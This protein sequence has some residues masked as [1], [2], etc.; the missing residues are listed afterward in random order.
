MLDLLTIWKVQFQFLLY[1]HHKRHFDIL[2][3]NNNLQKHLY[4]FSEDVSSLN[5]DI[6]LYY[7]SLLI[8]K[9]LQD[10]II[11]VFTFWLYVSYW[12]V[13]K[14]FERRLFSMF[15]SKPILSFV[16]CFSLRIYILPWLTSFS[17]LTKYC[18]TKYGLSLLMFRQ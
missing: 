16:F 9:D 18:A 8:F 5:F 10:K 12:N 13:I 2:E 4:N 3:C 1:L 17:W 15:F 6:S 14:L 11:S 7:L